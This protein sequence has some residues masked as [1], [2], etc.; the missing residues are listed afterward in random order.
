MKRISL[1][2]TVLLITVLSSRVLSQPDHASNNSLLWRISG[3]SLTKPSYI[4]G[5][6]HMICRDDYVWTKKMETSLAACDKVCL[7]MDID[8]PAVIA[9]VT[10]GLINNTGKKLKDYFTPAQYQLLKRYLKDSLGLDIS[11]LQQ[12]KPI[13]LESIMMTNGTDCADPV[14]YEDSILKT[15]H[16][17]DKEI[18]GLEDPEEQIAVLET[19]PVDTI[20]NA[21]I[22]EIQNT[23]KPD[24][25]YQQLIHAYKTQ[26]IKTLYTLI[27]LSKE[28]GDMALFLDGRNEKWIPRMEGKMKVS[29]VFFAVGAGH[30]WGDNGVLNLLRKAG[31]T[32]TS[33]NQ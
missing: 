16:K 28:L 29:S 32:V 25:D 4:F 6:M 24:T 14:S 10:T 33:A 12:M 9:K 22:E 1:L 27:N 17:T 21:L 31:Y 20:I 11:L 5:T 19:I 13:A 2:L 7:E 26:D 3:K 15:A 8:D 18:M 23:N 30:L